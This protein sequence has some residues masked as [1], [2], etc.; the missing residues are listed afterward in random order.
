MWERIHHAVRMAD[1]ARAGRE[2]SPTAAIIDS[3]SVRTG[4]Q[5]GARGYDAGKKVAWCSR[6]SSIAAVS[7]VSP[8]KCLIPC[9]D[10]A[11]FS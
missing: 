2:A 9:F 3:Q 6:R 4:D 5:G 10:G 8:A 1:R 11:V 7:T